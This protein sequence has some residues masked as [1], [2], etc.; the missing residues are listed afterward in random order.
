MALNGIPLQHEPDRLREFQTLIRHVHQQP[1]QMRRPCGWPSKN[2]QL[3]KLKRFETGSSAGSLSENQRF[4][5][6]VSEVGRVDAPRSGRGRLGRPPFLAGRSSMSRRGPGLGELPPLT[7]FK[8]SL[9]TRVLTLMTSSLGPFSA[10]ANKW[11]PPRLMGSGA[12]L[13]TPIK[14]QSSRRNAG[15]MSLMT[16]YP[17]LNLRSVCR[18]VA[19]MVR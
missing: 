17:A 18:L 6:R 11:M 5:L 4:F 8:N 2:C 10:K 19:R 7:N 3:T 1:T 15:S 9:G 13:P 12:D 16:S 14:R